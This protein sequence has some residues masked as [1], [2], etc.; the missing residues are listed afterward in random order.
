MAEHGR[1]DRRCGQA[2]QRRC[3]SQNQAG[4]EWECYIGQAA[5]Q[6]NI[7]SQGFLG[8]SAPAPGVG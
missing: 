8:Q 5:V 6:Q 3:R 1:G 7:I 4:T 2:R